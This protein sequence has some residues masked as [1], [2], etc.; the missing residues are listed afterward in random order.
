MQRHI[1]SKNYVEES[2]KE[3][4]MSVQEVAEL[5]S[6]LNTPAYELRELIGEFKG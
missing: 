2:M 3:Q 4:E 1:Y 5:A 6:C